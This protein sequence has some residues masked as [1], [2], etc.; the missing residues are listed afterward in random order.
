M[1]YWEHTGRPITERGLK[2]HNRRKAWVVNKRDRG[3]RGRL[4]HNRE[5]GWYIRDTRDKGREPFDYVLGDDDMIFI[6]RYSYTV[7]LARETV[8]VN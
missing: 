6:D 2:K 1:I 5:K 4:Y 7:R 3:A 8:T